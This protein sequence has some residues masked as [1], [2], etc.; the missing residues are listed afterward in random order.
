M[1]G[2]EF[3]Q[4]IRRFVKRKEVIGQIFTGICMVRMIRISHMVRR[5]KLPASFLAV[6]L[7]LLTLC[8]LIMASGTVDELPNLTGGVV[9]ILSYKDHD[10]FKSRQLTSVS[11]IEY[12]VR[13]KNQTGDPVVGDSLVVVIDKIIEISGQ[14]ISDRI[15]ISGA[16]G[17]TKDGRPY[18]QIPVGAK[19]DLAPYAESESITIELDNPDY[20]RFFPPTLQVRG[21]R[22]VSSESVQGLLDTL[23]NKGIITSDEASQALESPSATE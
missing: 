6:G 7:S 17:Q 19:K 23:V 4:K 5:A 2:A 22:R 3:K 13:V 21:K 11:H 8:P 1:E 12:V 18:F 14:D 16:D 9:P 20:L 15:V 10:P